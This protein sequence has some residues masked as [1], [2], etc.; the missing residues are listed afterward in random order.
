M[1]QTKKGNQTDGNLAKKGSDY[2]KRFTSI[3]TQMIIAVSLLVLLTATTIAVPATYFFSNELEEVYSET[4]NKGVEGLKNELEQRRTDAMRDVTVLAKNP[5]VIRAM[6]EKG[7]ADA[8]I[9]VLAPSVK[10]FNMDFLTVTDESGKVIVRIHDQ[11]KGDNIAKQL[12]VQKA[13]SG[14]VFGT[15]EEGPVIKFSARAGAPVQD[16]QGK[17]I[18]VISGGYDITK[19]AFID[20][21]KKLYGT[22]VT[23]FL[24]NERVATTLLKD[25]KRVIGTELNEQ[26]ST[27]VLKQGQNYKVRADILGMDYFTSYLPLL[28]KDDKPIGVLFAGVSTDSFIA[29]RTKMVFTIALIALGVSCLGAVCALYIAGKISNPIKAMLGNVQEVAAGNLT[30]EEIFVSSMNEIGQ[31]GIEFNKMNKRLKELIL[32]VSQA[33]EQVSASSEELTA[34]AQQSAQASNQVAAAIAQVAQG[35]EKQL[36]AV[37]NTA[38]VVQQMSAGIQQVASNAG[39]VSAVADKAFQAGQDG[40][41]S[42]EQVIA[43]MDSIEQGTVQVGDAIGKLSASSKQIGEIV[44]VISAIAAQTNLLALN[45]AIEAA[46]AGEQGR[47]FTVVADE[48]RKLA[49]QSGDAAK[50]ISSLID[51]N[52]QNIELAV[53]AMQN[54]NSEVKRGIAVVG[55]AG[56]AFAKIASL[57]QEVSAEVREIS[58]AVE[59]MASGSE[60]MVESMNDIK[61]VSKNTVG[62]TQ[63]VSAATEEQSASMQEIASAS[64]NLAKMAEGL[65]VA[66]ARFR[67]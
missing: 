43:Q 12:N 2:G 65:Q 33:T 41:T 21:V 60:Q 54:G 27:V 42:I 37:D 9:R 62:E 1:M 32:Q 45:A 52:K 67:L 51:E 3:K 26:I 22:D 5:S 4:A 8:L 50:Q 56:D 30:G 38:A 36:T 49:E 55:S 35:S 13:L 6:Q 24:G 20:Q 23:I 17:I 16:E 58:A 39:N 15:I 19:D 7:A 40:K 53:E 25:G 11:S 59:E 66:I 63:T 29:E 18:G 48:V 44:G 34:S 64:Q 57:V 14:T 10:E 46:R 61:K 28:G 31:L 47:G